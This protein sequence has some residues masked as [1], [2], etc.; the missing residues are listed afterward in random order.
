MP[1]IVHCSCGCVVI[2]LDRPDPDEPPE[3]QL[4]EVV[5]LWDC[6]PGRDEERY[7]CVR[8]TV[9]RAELD[10]GRPL[11]AAEETV[12]FVQLEKRLAA[13]RQAQYIFGALQ[14]VSELNQGRTDASPV[15][16]A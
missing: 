5:L 13:G 15:R 16:E 11:T 14:G 10:G 9:S 6:Q 7:T 12:L 1:V 8:S 2:P 3:A 4:V